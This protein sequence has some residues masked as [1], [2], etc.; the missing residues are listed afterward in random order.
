M[1]Y[2]ISIIQ[3]LD[4]KH[5]LEKCNEIRGYLDELEDKIF[6][7]WTTQVPEQCSMNLKKSLMLQAEET[8]ELS[9]NFDDSVRLNMY[10]RF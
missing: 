10:V 2:L 8:L 1:Y 5:L 7:E 4:F 3:S 9:L 6:Y